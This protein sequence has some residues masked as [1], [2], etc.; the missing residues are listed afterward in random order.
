[1]QE[2]KNVLN[3][4]T[5]GCDDISNLIWQYSN[6]NKT[7]EDYEWTEILWYFIKFVNNK[8]YEV[9]YKLIND[10]SK[11]YVLYYTKRDEFIFKTDHFKYSAITTYEWIVGKDYTQ[12]DRTVFNN[13]IQKRICE[14]K[15]S[16]FDS[17]SM[18]DSD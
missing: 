14:K 7:I 18:F 3:V 4:F 5:N 9:C 8:P 1:M 12:W 17:D 6:V 13:E 15:E 16:I 10:Y 11:E 2:T